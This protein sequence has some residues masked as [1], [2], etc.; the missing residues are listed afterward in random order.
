MRPETSPMQKFPSLFSFLEYEVERK[1]DNN[2]LALMPVYVEQ[3]P[4]LIFKFIRGYGNKTK[5]SEFIP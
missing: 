4:L 1:E 3:S 5:L 2:T